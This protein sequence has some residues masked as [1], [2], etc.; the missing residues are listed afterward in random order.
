MQP[1]IRYKLGGLRPLGKPFC[2]PLRDRRT[3]VELPSARSCVPAQLPG[4]R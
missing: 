4:N 1:F 3:V 2:L